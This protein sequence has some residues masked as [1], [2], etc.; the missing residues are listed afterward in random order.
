MLEVEAGGNVLDMLAHGASQSE[1]LRL[2]LHIQAAAD[3]FSHYPQLTVGALSVFE[4][5]E[6]FILKAGGSE[7]GFSRGSCLR[8]FQ[9]VPG[10]VHQTGWYV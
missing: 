9:E 10:S 2:R 3:N 5:P 8:G 4:V 7:Y 1:G 6:G